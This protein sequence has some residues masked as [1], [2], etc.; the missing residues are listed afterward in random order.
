MEMAMWGKL[1]RL[2]ESIFRRKTAEVEKQFLQAFAQACAGEEVAAIA[3][4][5]KAS[6]RARVPAAVTVPAAAVA[7]AGYEPRPLVTGA[8]SA[9]AMSALPGVPLPA[10][11]SA[12][13]ATPTV[14]PGEAAAR[15]T[16]S[17][18]PLDREQPATGRAHRAAVAVAGLAA[19]AVLGWFLGR[20]GVR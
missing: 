13:P 11:A 12:R 5:A 8:I 9:P 1:G 17:L 7:P 16:A 6:G 20:E 14:T 18:R 3:S 10:A 4:P 15:T 19:A 2:G